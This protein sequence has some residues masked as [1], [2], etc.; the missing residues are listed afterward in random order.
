MSFCA[1]YEKNLARNQANNRYA[2]AHSRKKV[3]YLA[4]QVN[5][6]VYHHRPQDE[7]DRLLRKLSAATGVVC[8]LGS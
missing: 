7:I 5:L 4:D 3:L 2:Y 1:D 8:G 6:A